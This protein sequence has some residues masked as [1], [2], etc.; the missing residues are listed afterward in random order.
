MQNLKKKLFIFFLSL[1]LLIGSINS[2]NS[3]ISFDE[4]YEELN[5]NFHVSVVKNF[6]NTITNQENFNKKEFDEKVKSF[7]G[8][9]IGFQLISQPIQ[10]FIKDLI[11]R[12]KNIDDFG[13]KLLAKHFVIFLFFFMSGIFFYLIL[14]KIIDNENFTIIGTIIYLTYPYLFGQAM[15]SPKDIP[16]M[17]VWVVLN[18]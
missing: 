12:N 10:F 6:T 16:F 18:M 1:Y 9:G 7:V 17:S 13:A 2:V 11:K 14:K 8:Y 5:W 4:N 15:F 3:G